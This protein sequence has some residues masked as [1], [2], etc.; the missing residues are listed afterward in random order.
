MNIVEINV[1]VPKKTPAMSPL[2]MVHT[3]GSVTAIIPCMYWKR[4]DRLGFGCARCQCWMA[5][6][7]WRLPAARPQSQERWF[8]S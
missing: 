1:I 6:D 4:D 5:G 8:R 3:C 2:I 7:G